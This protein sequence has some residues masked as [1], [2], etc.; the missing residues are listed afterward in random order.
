[1]TVITEV[2]AAYEQYI[3]AR[4]EFRARTFGARIEAELADSQDVQRFED[5]KAASREVAHATSRTRRARRSLQR[6]TDPD[7]ILKLTAELHGAQEAEVRARATFEERKKAD[8]GWAAVA[9]T[10][11]FIRAA[12]WPALAVLA[13]L[14]AYSVAALSWKP[15]E[16]PA[17][18]E[19][20][21]AYTHV[22]RRGAVGIG[23]IIGCGLFAI[24]Y[25]VLVVAGIAGGV[26]VAVVILGAGLGLRRW[27]KT[28][29]RHE[30]AVLGISPS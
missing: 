25:A 9:A 17:A 8:R 22:L 13:A 10:G 5:F 19:D 21:N 12:F 16:D 28:S 3:A 26:I 29:S 11:R 18:T 15:A 20:D 27:L 14:A 4:L 23:A 7:E 2:H 6:V 30:N 1:M 24:A